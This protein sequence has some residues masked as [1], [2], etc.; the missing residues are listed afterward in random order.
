M[1]CVEHEAA[2]YAVLRDHGLPT[3][4]V[5]RAETSPVNPLGWQYLL[6]EALPG[7][8]VTELSPAE[9]PAALR[10]VG[11]YLRRM[12]AIHFDRPGYLYRDGPPATLDPNEWQHAIWTF[13]TFDRTRQQDGDAAE[14]FVRA[15]LPAIRDSYVALRFTHGDCHA[16]QFF[17]ER[18]E[19]RCRVTGVVD[20]EVAS[21]GDCGWDLVKF[22]IEAAVRWEPAS[23][24]WEPFL[25]GYGADVS[26]PVF[27][28]RLLTAGPENF[29]CLR[30]P[31][32]WPLD[33]EAL[34]RHVLLA[35]DWGEL[36]SLTESHG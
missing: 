7:R 25:D 5:V 28:A 14:E 2:A 31:H 34:I 29:G 13:A 16:H 36:F 4:K 11:D 21:A 17:V 30:G 8:A 24:W 6:L 20:M 26:L 19:S 1:R 27:K 9:L 10:T 33:R 15:Q 22:M 12:H 32:T 3:V 35:Q 23:R 18:A